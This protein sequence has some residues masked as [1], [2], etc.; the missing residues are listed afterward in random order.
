MKYMAAVLLL[1]AAMSA[2]NAPSTNK[3]RHLDIPAISREAN[4]AI[5]SI[6]MS[7]KDGHPIAKGSGFFISKDGHVLTNYHVIR[8][9]SSAVIK[10]PNGA[11]FAVD[12]VLASDKDRDVAVIKAHG[13]DFRTLTLGDSDRLQVGEEVVAIGNPLSLES[14]VSNGIVSAVRT[15]ETEGGDFLQI[16]APISP[17]SSGGPLFN[18]AGEVVGITTSHLV[19][20]QNLNFAI[21]IND[22]KLM[23]RSTLSRVRALPDEPEPDEK[24]DETNA[25]VRATQAAHE[26]QESALKAQHEAE[27][28]KARADMLARWEQKVASDPFVPP[29]EGWMHVSP[30]S[31]GALYYIILPGETKDSCHFSSQGGNPALECLGAAGRNRYSAMQSGDRWYLLKSG[32]IASGVYAGTVKD[33]GSTIC[34]RKSGCHYVLAEVR[35]VPTEAPEEFVAAP[36][37]VNSWDTNV[38]HVDLLSGLHFPRPDISEAKRQ[39]E[40]AT[41]RSLN[42]K[43]NAAKLAAD[44]GNYDEAVATLTEANQIDSSRDL[45]WFKLGDYYRM[46][47]DKQTDSAEKQKRLESAVGAYQKAVQLRQAAPAD[48]DPAAAAKALAAYYNNLAEAYAKSNKVDDAVKIYALAAQTD[49]TAAGQYYFN[50]GAVLTNAGEVDDAIAAFDKVIA[51]DPTKADAYYWRGWCYQSKK[52]FDM[53]L[54]DYNKVLELNP[55]YSNAVMGRARLFDSTHEFSKAIAEYEKAIGLD[56]NCLE[57][58]NS[59]AWLLSTAPA[60]GVRNGAKAVEYGHK[61]LALADKGES[62]IY[63]DTLAAAYAEAGRFAD[64][65]ALQSK[66]I[67]LIPKDYDAKESVAFTARLQFYKEN[68]PYRGPTSPSPKNSYSSWSGVIVVDHIYTLTDG[69]KAK[70]HMALSDHTISRFEIG[71]LA[72]YPDCAQLTVGGK[73]KIEKMLKGDPDVYHSVEDDYNL[74]SV[75]VT[76]SEQ[77]AVYFVVNQQSAAAR[78][79]EA[80]EARQDEAEPNSPAHAPA[81][82]SPDPKDSSN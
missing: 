40:L 49:P 55:K 17:G 57:A 75:R 47:A 1:V 76:G 11:F 59:L 34:L 8:N 30:L 24:A 37:D 67:S 72:K 28:A 79:D 31:Y 66:A 45:I 69:Y 56:P 4:G 42:E 33:G 27:I 36:R 53:A 14:T 26:A 21:P 54:A 78:S 5:V 43:L 20:G 82:G 68:K 18:M 58:Y 41:V 23:L 50:T 7:D 46:S 25:E 70:V 80:E 22:V 44:A 64:A 71:C 16:T 9:G 32:R 61:A 48:K 51:A 10:L 19:G 13:N 63:M 39:K 2:Q 65:V 38:A 15:I 81:R 6:V 29:V 12:G 73:F 62:F 35:P 77:S 60:D 52:V 74:G 3:G